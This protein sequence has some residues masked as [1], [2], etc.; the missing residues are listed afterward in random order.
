MPDATGFEVDWEYDD[1]WANDL[2]VDRFVALTN[3]QEDT[4]TLLEYE[5]NWA[6]DLHVGRLSR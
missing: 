3:R 2:Y 6:D 4:T 5:D 1:N